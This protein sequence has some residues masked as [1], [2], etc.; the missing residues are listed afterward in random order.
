MGERTAIAARCRA[1]SPMP[2]RRR[3]CIRVAGLCLGCERTAI[4]ARSRFG[5]EMASRVACQRLV[6]EMACYRS[7]KNQRSTT[8]RCCVEHRRQPG[9]VW[10]SHANGLLPRTV[11]GKCPMSLCLQDNFRSGWSVISLR[12]V[13]YR[14]PGEALTAAPAALGGACGSIRWSEGCRMGCGLYEVADGS[15]SLFLP[16]CFGKR[17]DLEYWYGWVMR[18]ALSGCLILVCEVDAVSRL[19][20]VDVSGTGHMSARAIARPG[21]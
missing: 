20:A 6:S 13:C 15:L 17:R 11:S 7:P 3:A 9:L 14:S 5:C 4:A 1:T 10:A 8:A 19:S 16:W 21:Y 12:K 2:P 18:E